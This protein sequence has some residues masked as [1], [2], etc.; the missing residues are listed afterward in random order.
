MKRLERSYSSRNPRAWTP[1]TS[2]PLTKSCLAAALYLLSRGPPGV[3]SDW[4]ENQGESPIPGL[5]LASMP[6]SC[7][8]HQPFF[9]LTSKVKT[10]QWAQPCVVQAPGY[11]L[12]L[13]IFLINLF[14]AVLGLCCY[15]WVFS[16]FGVRAS[17]CS[18][19]SCGVWAQ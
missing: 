5:P 4:P 6:W 2:W 12:D 16:S 3:N 18:G 14:L 9:H 8:L 15:V 11:G 17:P 10:Y 19:F 13:K 7:L 1:P